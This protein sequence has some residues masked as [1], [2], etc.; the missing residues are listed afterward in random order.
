[1]EYEINK[2]YNR[3]L[4]IHGKYG[5]QQQGGICTPANA[6]FIFLFTGETGEQYGYKDG[7]DEDGVFLYTGEGQVGPMEFVRGNKAIRDHESNGKDLLLFQA[8]GNNKGYRF[9]GSYACA[10]YEF[11]EA[12]DRD[13]AIRRVIVFHLVNSDLEVVEQN[14]IIP[15]TNDK[16]LSIEQLKTRAYDA[17]NPNEGVAGKV[18]KTV[19]RKRSQAVKEY[20]LARANGICESCKLPAPFKRKDGSDYLEPHHIRR[21]SDGGP[22]HP[23][24]VAGIC[25]NC[26]REI[27]FGLDGRLLNQQLQ[28]YVAGVE[29]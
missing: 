17:S 3:R 13:G 19:Y 15:I 23:K 21:V 20:V 4:H 27:H 7:P 25:P 22:D 8:I 16:K 10:N 29:R 5:G 12:P 1:M 2:V 6:P 9:L 26:H 28:D 14:E 18:A 11:R 24:W